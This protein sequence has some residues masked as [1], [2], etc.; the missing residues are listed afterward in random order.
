MLVYYVR[1]AAD[2]QLCKGKGKV[3]K[4]PSIDFSVLCRSSLDAMCCL[5]HLFVKKYAGVDIDICDGVVTIVRSKLDS[6]SFVIDYLYCDG[7]KQPV[8][9]HDVKKSLFEFQTKFY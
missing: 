8:C 3:C 2:Q 7:I 6:R 4:F 9:L 1:W 5:Q